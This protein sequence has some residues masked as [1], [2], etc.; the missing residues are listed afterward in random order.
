[1]MSAFCLT[2]YALLSV[3]YSDRAVLRD[4][5]TSLAV[6][7]FFLAFA[8]FF[9]ICKHNYGG[10]DGGGSGSGNSHGR[11]LPLP[12]YEE[13]LECERKRSSMDKEDPESPREEAPDS[14]SV[15]SQR[16]ASQLSSSSTFS[17]EEELPSFERA[18]YM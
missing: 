5:V 2:T 16:S 14:V 11:E 10:G 4:Y 6:T 12:S 1:M 9:G 15:S 17:T 8:C 7:E 18:V 3:D 13:A